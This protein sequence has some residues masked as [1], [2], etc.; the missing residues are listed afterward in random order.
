ME[1]DFEG[2]SAIL[3]TNFWDKADKYELEVQQQYFCA[4]ISRISMP[5]HAYNAD[6]PSG[7]NL[8]VDRRTMSRKR[9]GPKWL[10]VPEHEQISSALILYSPAWDLQRFFLPSG[11]Y[12]SGNCPTIT[13]C[14]QPRRL[15]SKSRPGS[16]VNR[17]YGRSKV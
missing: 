8:L 2:V 3:Y 13:S 14:L 4:A 15:V 12:L 16:G 9:I 5:H 7:Y 6:H 1:A 17:E 10:F 11:A